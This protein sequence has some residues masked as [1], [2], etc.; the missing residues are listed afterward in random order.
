[1]RDLMLANTT[2]D[3][4]VMNNPSSAPSVWAIL[5]TKLPTK[6][7]TKS[8]TNSPTNSPTK[9]PT[10]KPTNQPTNQPTKE[11]T[12]PPT[13]FPTSPPSQQAKTEYPSSG[14]TYECHDLE[15]YR[16]PINELRCRDHRH[17]NC[18]KW[19]CLGLTDA[20]IVDL[21]RSCPRSCNV[22]CG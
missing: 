18:V 11:P 3:E 6:T 4:F 21:L 19:K 16:S 22:D 15:S 8:P 1:M 20:D 13:T 2:S 12:K 14:P 17:T 5:P 10:N 9:Q 7:P